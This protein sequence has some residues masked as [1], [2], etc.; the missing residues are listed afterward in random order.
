MDRS[1]FSI[2]VGLVPSDWCVD[3]EAPPILSSFLA[4]SKSFN[5]QMRVLNHAG[6]STFYRACLSLSSMSIDCLLS[7]RW[8]NCLPLPADEQ[9]LIRL[10]TFLADSLTHS[11]I[12]AYLSVGSL[13]SH[14]QWFSRPIG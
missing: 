13:P 5:G 7:S 10:C 4:T 8:L 1:R 12:K 14:Q 9:F 11:S 3:G 2:T 6:L